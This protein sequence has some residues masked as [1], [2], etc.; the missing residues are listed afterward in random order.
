MTQDT[1]D[2]APPVRRPGCGGGCLLR[3]L[4]AIAVLV[5]I[6]VAI[7]L[8]FDQ[9]GKATQPARQYVAGPAAEYKLGDVNQFEP[10]HLFLVRLPDGEFLAFYDKSSRQQEL[11]G[12]CRL[13]Y[14]ETAGVGTLEPIAGLG[15][16]F[17][18]ECEGSR[19][20]W[21]VDGKY[22]FGNG[23]G[24]LDRFNVSV[25]DAGDVVIDLSTRSCTRSKGVPGIE[26]FEVR[27]CGPP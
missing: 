20:V 2:A 25:D 16:A 6:G 1:A 23:Y 17:V 24:D 22:S 26:P 4:A 21:R 9:G 19:A 27:T 13:R 18:E 8:I 12:S 7:G 5:A 15:G 3:G 14:D 11:G 10:Q